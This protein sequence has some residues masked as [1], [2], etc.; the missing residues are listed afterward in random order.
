[1]RESIPWRA[2]V[3]ARHNPPPNETQDALI[4]R[5]LA[6]IEGLQEE[7]KRK[8]G[9]RMAC[10]QCGSNLLV[11][12]GSLT[13]CNQCGHG[14]DTK[15]KKKVWAPVSTTSYIQPGT[16][17]PGANSPSLTATCPFCEGGN[18]A[19]KRFGSSKF[20]WQCP[21]GHCF[22]LNAKGSGE[23]ELLNTENTGPIFS[24]GN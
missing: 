24:G 9:E 10:E 3:R 17:S 8:Q 12:I 16:P 11:Q 2:W 19:A 1:M 7:E 15:A 6:E 22:S 23:V 18:V 14:V 13:R 21:N 5:W 20:E 4:G